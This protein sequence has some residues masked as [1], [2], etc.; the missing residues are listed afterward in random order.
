MRSIDEGRQMTDWESSEMSSGSGTFDEIE[1][2]HTQLREDIS[3]SNNLDVSSSR[4]LMLKKLHRVFNHE[5]LTIQ[6]N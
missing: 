4:I 3:K 2:I 1:S 5:L 6:L